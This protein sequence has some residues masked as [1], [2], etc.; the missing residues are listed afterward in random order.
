MLC[1]LT[2]PLIGA[3]AHVHGAGREV[4]VGPAQAAQL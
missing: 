1:R 3:L 4:D 2:A